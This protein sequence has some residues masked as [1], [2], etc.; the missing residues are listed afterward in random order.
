MNTNNWVCKSIVLLLISLALASCDKEKHLEGGELTEQSATLEIITKDK[1]ELADPYTL[2]SI[3]IDKPEIEQTT[4]D[5][6]AH[7]TLSTEGEKAISISIDEEAAKKYGKGNVKLLPS[8]AISIPKEIT[9]IPAFAVTSEPISVTINLTDEIEFDEI[10]T[11]ALRLDPINGAKMNKPNDVV[12]F[13]LLREENKVQVK[14]AVLLTR[15]FYFDLAKDFSHR[16]DFT[17]ECLVNAEKFR[18]SEDEGEAQIST[19]MGI[20]GGTLLRFGDAGVPGNK[21]QAAG[22]VIDLP[23]E[24]K[25]WY[26]VA[27]TYEAATQIVTVYIDGEMKSSFRK[28][29]SIVPRGDKW[30]IGRSWSSNRGLQAMLAEVRVWQSVRKPSEIMEHMMQEDPKNPDLLAYWKMNSADGEK[31]TDLTGNGYD[32]I[33]KVQQGS[34]DPKVNVVTLDT[35]LDSVEK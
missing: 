9:P 30:Y 31:V 1:T 20:E 33:L 24:T 5:L 26:H 12:I 2:R 6:R 19:L 16:G 34:A 3:E 28:P 29:C 10:Y 15:D 27:F 32:L 25:A 23:F 18:D 4:I 14:K 17:M 35:P 21:L 11:F 22:E 7:L 8:S 13:T